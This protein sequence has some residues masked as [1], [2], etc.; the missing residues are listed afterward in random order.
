MS[1]QLRDLLGLDEGERV[2]VTLDC[3]DPFE[4]RIPP[5]FLAEACIPEDCPL[6]V[7]VDGGRVVIQE[8]IDG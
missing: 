3:D 6:E 7:Y 4:L 2:T 8:A 1:K 5:E